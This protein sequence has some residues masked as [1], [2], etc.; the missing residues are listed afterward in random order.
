M[1][2]DWLCG[3]GWVIAPL[4]LSFLLC[5]MVVCTCGGAFCLTF[6]NS[7]GAAMGWCDGDVRWAGPAAPG[8]ARSTL[9]LFLS[10]TCLGRSHPEAKKGLKCRGCLA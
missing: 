4:N 8:Q 5:E 1:A 7:G 2:T 9:G 10:V 3:P 6:G